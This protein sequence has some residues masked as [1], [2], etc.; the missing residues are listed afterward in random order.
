MQLRIENTMSKWS[1]F[2]WAFDSTFLCLV[3][4]RFA[5]T[6]VSFLRRVCSNVKVMYGCPMKASQCMPHTYIAWDGVITTSSNTSVVNQPQA[7]TMSL[8]TCSPVLRQCGQNYCQDH[9]A[10]KRASISQY[11]NNCIYTTDSPS[12]YTS[13][14]W[15]YQLL[16]LSRPQV[17]QDH[18]DFSK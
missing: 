13:S 18:S 4:A 3:C 11:L 7:R 2:G 15:L 14:N 5:T 1:D 10:E 9:A 12:I 17:F 8:E 16:N 6:L